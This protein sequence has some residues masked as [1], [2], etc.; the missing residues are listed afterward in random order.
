M[1][2]TVLLFSVAQ[3]ISY[4]LPANRSNTEPVNVSTPNL[5]NKSTSTQRDIINR[6]PLLDSPP[7]STKF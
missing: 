2:S 3:I 6:K 4:H 1:Y 5:C 7:P